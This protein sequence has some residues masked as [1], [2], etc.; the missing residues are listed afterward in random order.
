MISELQRGDL[1]K[2]FDYKNKEWT[3]SRFVTYLHKDDEMTT[4]YVKV[5]TSTNKT[6][7]ISSLHLIAKTNEMSSSKIEFIF[8]KDLKTS[9]YLITEDSIEQ[10]T[11]IERVYEKGAYAP[12]T[13]SGTISVNSIVASCYANTKYYNIAHLLFQP[14]IQFSK[15]FNIDSVTL[16]HYFAAE[17]SDYILPS[18]AF[19]YAKF[20]FNLISSLPYS[21]TLIT[22]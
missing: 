20:V 19:W 7:S 22:L 13:E 1:V 21:S 3:F 18:D 2:S 10:V 16:E 4:E 15:Y 8:A 12:L 5:K 11:E 6:I 9:D 17:S 14:L